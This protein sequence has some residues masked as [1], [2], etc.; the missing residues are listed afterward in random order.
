MPTRSTGN[1]AHRDLKAAGHQVVFESDDDTGMSLSMTNWRYWLLGVAILFAV[2]GLVL[3]L[4]T[5]PAVN[6]K[7]EAESLGYVIGTAIGGMLCT[8]LVPGIFF[9]AARSSSSDRAKRGCF[10][11]CV[12]SALALS[13][14]YCGY[15]GLGLAWHGTRG[16][17]DAREAAFKTAFE[18]LD[19]YA[20]SADK[21]RDAFFN[22]GGTRVNTLIG[23]DTIAAR[24]ALVNKLKVACAESTKLLETAEPT[25][26]A[27]FEQAGVSIFAR[28]MFWN[29][30]LGH[31]Y[32]EAL[33]N[34]RAVE[35]KVT[36][37]VSEYLG[38]MHRLTGRFATADSNNVYFKEQAD[39]ETY[40]AALKKLD[41]VLK[42]Y[43]DAQDRL[44]ACKAMIK[45]REA[46]RR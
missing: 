18:T 39:L 3:A 5:A 21:A 15:A 36:A 30:R 38:V 2:I 32:T 24:I 35:T 29:E 9:L 37:A 8:G 11:V 45:K 33:L 1:N 19:S 6:L 10:L 41:P 13:L 7:G 43:E 17:R 44:A 28:D 46:K 16:A 25:L 26:D 27:W 34:L 12:I 42:A 31:E 22:A 4:I 14:A 20:A 40:Q 23:A